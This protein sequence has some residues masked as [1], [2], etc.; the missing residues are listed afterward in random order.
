[1]SRKS[2]GA[3]VISLD[4]E[5]VW[6]MYNTGPISPERYAGTRDV[7]HKLL[8]LFD[9]YQIP[10]TWALVTHLLSDCG[11]EP[12][13]RSHLQYTKQDSRKMDLPCQQELS[14]DLW[15]E[16]EVLNW[17][18]NTEVDHDIG[19]HTHTHL[20]FNE[21]T[22][23][24]ARSDVERSVAVAERYG[25]DL[26]SF[27]FPRNRIDHRGVLKDAGFEVY[28]GV[29][30]R[31]YE[32]YRLPAPIVKATRFADEATQWTPP[33]VV[34][35]MESGLVEVPGSQVFRPV[36][37]GWQYTPKGSQQSRAIAGLNRAARTGRIFHLWFH[38]FNFASNP[39][40]LLTAFETVLAH[41]ESLVQ[42]GRLNVLTMRNVADL[43]KSGRWD[44]WETE[45]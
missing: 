19:S 29:D 5:L 45:V 33:T 27:V 42:Q 39:E 31:W 6:G 36:H 26:K 30:S 12:E 1:M 44:G 23:E 7:V 15:H 25:I 24:D 10:V 21:A 4:T 34:P 37:G 22:R 38:P 13:D 32:K 16:P 9:K 17:I 28:R 20:V 40:Q 11:S 18:K 14:P 35:R 41:A 43:H 8:D 2:S 3:L